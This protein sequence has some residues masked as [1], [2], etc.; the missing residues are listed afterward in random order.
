VFLKHNDN[1][2]S[3]D[4]GDDGDDDVTDTLQEAIRHVE[5]QTCIRFSRTTQTNSPYLLVSLGGR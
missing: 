2:L 5:S 3:D 4:D 1:L